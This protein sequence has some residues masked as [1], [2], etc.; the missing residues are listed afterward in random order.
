VDSCVRRNDGG[1]GGVDSCVRRNDGGEGGVDSCVRRNDGGGLDGAPMPRYV[2][3]CEKRELCSTICMMRVKTFPL[4]W[5][6]ALDP[7]RI[8]YGIICHTSL[9][10]VADMRQRKAE[11]IRVRALVQRCS[12]EQKAVTWLEQARWGG[13]PVCPHG[14]GWST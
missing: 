5:F 10:W 9:L 13:Q 2:S 8:S 1:E 4:C 3:T 7:V 11:T 12:T 6:Q 14:E